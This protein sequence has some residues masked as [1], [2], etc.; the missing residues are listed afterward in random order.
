VQHAPRDLEDF[1]QEGIR[2]GDAVDQRTD[3]NETFVKFEQVLQSGV[4]GAH[5]KSAATQSIGVAGDKRGFAAGAIAR[6]Q[7][8]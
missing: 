3:L 7:I 5:A 8:E 4:C 1:R 2:L 6:A